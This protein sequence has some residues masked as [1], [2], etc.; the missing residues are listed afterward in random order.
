MHI[1][2]IIPNLKSYY[3]LIN[4]Y[5]INSLHIITLI[6]YLNCIKSWIL[7]FK[8]T[9]INLSSKMYFSYVIVF[10]FYMQVSKS[11]LPN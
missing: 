4:R 1:L 11:S 9:G 5:H 8:I 7:D 3:I 10:I 6:L 2:N